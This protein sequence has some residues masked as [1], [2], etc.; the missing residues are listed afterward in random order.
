[1]TKSK[2]VG[3]LLGTSGLLFVIGLTHKSS[4]LGAVLGYWIGF[5]YTQSLYKDTQ[6]SAELEVS[7]AIRRMRRGFFGRLGFVTLVVAA[8]GR[9]QK[10]WL[11]SLAIG[12]ALGLVVSLFIELK[13][14]VKSGEG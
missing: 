7:L 4:I 8:V 1:M 13:E 3:L 11:F 9:Y 2:F 14:F 10:S 5:W 6:S 12:I